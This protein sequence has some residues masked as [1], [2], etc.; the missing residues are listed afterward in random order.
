MLTEYDGAG[1]ILSHYGYGPG[2]DEPILWWDMSAGGALKRLHA[3]ERGSIVAVTDGTGAVLGINSYDEY[4]QPGASNIG[5]FQY[6]G[7]MWLGEIGLQYSKARMYDPRNGRFLQTDPIGYEAGTNLYTYVG[8]DPVNFIDPSGLEDI[9]VIGKRPDQWD[10]WGGSWFWADYG[11]GSG[12][13]GV[14][15]SG[16]DGGMGGPFEPVEDDEEENAQCAAPPISEKERKA[17]A[18]GNRQ[19]FWQSRKMRGDPLGA[20]SLSIATNSSFWGQFANVRL[21]DTISSRSP[22]MSTSAI[23]AEVQ[24]IGIELMRAHVRAV[25]GFGNPSPMQIAGYHFR[26]FKNH[27]LPNTTFGGSMITGTQA[28]AWFT[29]PGWAECN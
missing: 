27:N 20:T 16:G 10:P 22:S 21:R 3:D 17:A 15:E 6:T 19:S 11:S 5:R 1:T 2:T 7:Q 14:G 26:V 25:D 28:E 29:W 4:G 9:V 23:S 8:N 12:V 24:Q 13:G 18:S